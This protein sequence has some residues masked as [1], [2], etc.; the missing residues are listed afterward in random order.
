VDYASYHQDGTPHIVRR[1][2]VPDQAGGLGPIWTEG[3]RK[4]I[5][6]ALEQAMKPGTH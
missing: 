6:L 3:F 1:Q 2:I 5:G 4:E